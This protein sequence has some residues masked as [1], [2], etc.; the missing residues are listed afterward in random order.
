MP[1]SRR[2]RGAL[3]FWSLQTRLKDDCAIP[4]GCHPEPF[5]DVFAVDDWA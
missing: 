3:R 5:V 2:E 1:V 4:V